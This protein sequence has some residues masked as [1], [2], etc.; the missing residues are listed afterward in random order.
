MSTVPALDN[1]R[2]N[3]RDQLALAGMSQRDLS[4]RSGIHWVTINRILSGV[5]EPTVPVAERLADAV[6]KPFESLVSAAAPSVIP[7]AAAK[8]NLSSNIQRLLADRGMTQKQLA[9]ATGETEMTISRVVRGLHL[10]SVG[11]VA[12]IAEAFDVSIDR[13]VARPP[14]K[15]SAK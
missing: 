14:G 3:L 4:A 15:I 2:R 6:G 7:D 11:I 10:P 13:I 9:E 8:Q 1:F 5:Q 12:R